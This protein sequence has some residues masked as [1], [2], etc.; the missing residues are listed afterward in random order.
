MEANHQ[1]KERNKDVH[2]HS[3]PVGNKE[4][5]RG[6]HGNRDGDG[7]GNN[8][9]HL[10]H[11]NVGVLLQK[12]KLLDVLAGR[13]YLWY[14]LQLHGIPRGEWER[15]VKG[16]QGQTEHSLGAGTQISEVSSNLSYSMTHG[17]CAIVRSQL[18][19]L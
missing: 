11:G 5:K 18:L 1:R 2:V 16:S 9:F 14:D 10:L 4:S 7:N 19:S 3:F 13:A 6:A 8:P 17:S 12:N 15:K